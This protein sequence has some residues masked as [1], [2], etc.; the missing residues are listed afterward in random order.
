MT[1]RAEVMVRAPVGE[2]APSMA[3]AKPIGRSG[4]MMSVRAFSPSLTWVSA[5][6][7]AS[8]MLRSASRS[9]S[10]NRTSS[11]PSRARSARLFS[12]AIC[13]ALKEE[14]SGRPARTSVPGLTSMRSRCA[15]RVGSRKAL[16]YQLIIYK[17]DISQSTQQM[18]I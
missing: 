4:P 6:K 3:E 8:R 12:V 17:H 2:A 14:S 16:I 5:T 1:S 15:T 9:P 18:S 13:V 10:R 7:P 11:G